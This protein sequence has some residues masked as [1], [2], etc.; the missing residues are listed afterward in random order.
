MKGAFLD[1][2]SLDRQDLDFSYFDSVLDEWQIHEATS[3]AEVASRIR[4]VDLVVSNKVVLDN[5]ML[6]ANP[7]LQL[8]CVAATGTNNVDLEAARANAI[9][10]CNVTGYATA[11]VVE[12]VF[13]LLLS[14][15]RRLPDYQRAINEQRW[16]QSDQFC[17]L[18]YPIEELSGK[19]LGI[20]GYGELGQAVARMGQAFGMQ[21]LVARRTAK[22]SRADRIAL[23]DLLAKVDVLSLH[24]PLTAETQ[25]LI[26]GPQLALMK[27]SAILINTA[28]GGVVDEAALLQALQQGQLA[29][30]GIDVLEREPPQENNPLLGATLPQLIITP[31][32]AWAS[33]ASRQRLLD[34]VADNIESFKK[35]ALRN[36]L[37]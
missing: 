6:S 19:T 17:L 29:G 12:H 25:H 11:S 15:L 3:T 34:Q 27:P 23:E 30:A 8:I 4:D 7:Q 1:K 36:R 28:R 35:G 2:A 26:A 10:V 20:V 18:D 13:M 14:L 37:V 16:Q 32:I 22:D 24:C 31:H 9:Q 5:E 33:R 21:V